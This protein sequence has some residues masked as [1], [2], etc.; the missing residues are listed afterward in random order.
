M[1]Q[2]SLEQFIALSSQIRLYSAPSIE[3]IMNDNEYLST[4]VRNFTKIG[5][6]SEELNETLDSY[7]YPLLEA[8]RHLSDEET[9][10]LLS[11]SRGLVDMYSVS[12]LDPMICYLISCKLVED[13]D[14][15][16]D[17]RALIH[18]LDSQVEAAF[19]MVELALRLMPCDDIGLTYRQKGIEAGT[20]L[21]SYLEKSRF[22]AL[23]DED[24][25]EKVLINSRYI[26]SLLYQNCA[27]ED[28]ENQADLELLQR[29]MALAD[30]PFYREQA[31]EYN[32]DYHT[33]RCLQYMVSYSERLNQRGMNDEQ[34]ECLYGYA[35]R[36]IY[37]W[38][39]DVNKYRH[40]CDRHTLDLY[41]ARLGFLTGRLSGDEYKLHLRNLMSQANLFQFGIHDN[42]MSLFVLD[43][44]LLAA[45]HLGM[46]EQD[47][48]ALG[49]QYRNLVL[50]TN[51]M[52]KLDSISFATANISHVL[53]DYADLPLG[54]FEEFCLQMVAAMHP[55]TYV[56][57]LTVASLVRLLA[58]HL[59]EE[60]P[61]V[62]I[63]FRGA[64]TTEE[65]LA[66]SQEILNHAEHAALCHDIGKL[67]VI[68]IIMTYGRR[69]TDQEFAIVKSHSAIG[70]YILK[71]HE[72]TKDLFAVALCHHDSGDTLEKR[73]KNGIIDPSERPFID[74]TCCADSLDAATDAVGR[75]YKKGKS[76]DEVVAELDAE[77]GT[78]Y[79]SYV[80][81]LLHKADLVAEVKAILSEGRE[82]NYRRAYKFLYDIASE[83]TPA[84]S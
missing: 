4:L 82:E 57:S 74:I 47:Q 31:P 58:S 25:K 62:F 19:A 43:E 1:P 42:I 17:E 48:A 67:F 12:T 84:S 11:F 16:Q 38:E 14:Y 29:S 75:S 70:A 46:D 28:A 9:E 79:A 23:P 7:V 5:V 54:G 64:Q 41:Q 6:L 80:V 15:K 2:Q 35:E 20:R 3:S 68:E 56:H 30:D 26:S 34:L 10:G 83:D 13:A 71:Q 65:V 50:Y 76:F 81:D 27:K 77:S 24:C 40:Y 45:K 78:R 18:A 8:D 36:L 63:G 51:R 55:L 59:L 73:I 32:W 49:R 37:I 53:K 66:L 39:S 61:E 72:E 22:S 52:P 44:Y 33:F 60:S 21:L 69:L